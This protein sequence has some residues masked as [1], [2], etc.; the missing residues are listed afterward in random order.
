M[1]VYIYIYCF[2]FKFWFQSI[3]TF[4]FDLHFLLHFPSNQTGKEFDANVKCF[5][6]DLWFF[7]FAGSLR[8]PV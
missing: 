8:E 4:V 1:C 7:Y 6:T 3:P 2:S 5:D